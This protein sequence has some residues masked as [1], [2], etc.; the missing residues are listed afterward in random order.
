VLLVV[1]DV[2]QYGVALEAALGRG[3]YRSCQVRPGSGMRR[4]GD[5]RFEADFDDPASLSA[6]AEAIR[7][8]TGAPVGGIV[9]LLG[10]DERFRRPDLQATDEPFRLAIWLLNLVKTFEA[11]V[12]ESVDAGAGLVVNLTS[13][14]G[15]FGLSGDRPLSVAQAA[16][17]GFFK[18]LS[19]EWRG[20]RVKNLDIDP[21]AEP[22]VL[23]SA[24]LAELV[25]WDDQLEVGINAKGRWNLDL[26]E[27]RESPA[28]TLESLS[29][30]L[31]LDAESVIL[32]TGGAQGITAEVLKHLAHETGATL[33]IVGRSP[34]TTRE[35]EPVE[36][37]DLADEAELRKSLIRSRNGSSET[38]P[39]RIEQELRRILKDR[40]IRNNL[41]AL[42]A[43]GSRVEYRA[44]DVR[45]ED[46]LAAFIEEAY[47][48]HGRIDGVIHGAGVVEDR[49]LKDKTP[50]SFERV[51]QTK[52]KPAMV[53][54]RVLRP[55]GLKFLSFFSSVSG[56]FGNAGQADY[57][58]ANECLNKLAVHLDREWP[59][60]VVAMNW[61][62]WDCGLISDAL[63]T[64]YTQR[65][66]E[67]IPV[68]AGSQAFI[69]ELS[70]G[71]ARAPEVVLACNAR[72]LAHAGVESADE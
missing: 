25:A 6:L 21:Q 70:R 33:V 4:L 52:V 66:I 62:P 19:K 11:D 20:V 65:G 22:E 27:E 29:A 51:F 47:R 61:G 7:K 38:T 45:D 55:A 28:A 3:G 69:E 44:L 37:R 8:E 48:H 50:E 39:A 41:E 60:R 31:A 35:D 58:A 2:A 1:G 24:I 30:E 15:C 32:A 56:R 59:G 49:W 57:S 54:A 67:L 68:V 72:G 12:R 71:D 23:L 26:V 16:S 13:L 9:N 53:L 43:A 5:R 10:L 17:L 63:R 18:S 42:R 36:L 46:A 64:A 14:D 34:L 40:A